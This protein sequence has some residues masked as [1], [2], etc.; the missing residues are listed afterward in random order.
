MLHSTDCR[1]IL[2]EMSKHPADKYA[3]TWAS[4]GAVHLH[5]A[6]VRAALAVLPAGWTCRFTRDSRG[7][8]R[9]LIEWSRAPGCRGRLLLRACGAA[10][11]GE[12]AREALEYCADGS[13]WKH[14]HVTSMPDEA[15]AAV[16]KCFPAKKYCSPTAITAK[17]A[18]E[19]ILQYGWRNYTVVEIQ[20]EE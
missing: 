19:R 17:D 15:W 20:D 16:R 12:R 2:L 11:L 7:A 4:G 18:Q 3:F 6:A 1:E 8:R 9:L 5:G 14:F 10:D 13:T